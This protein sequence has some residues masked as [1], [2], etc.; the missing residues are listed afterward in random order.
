MLNRLFDYE[1]LSTGQWSLTVGSIAAVATIML[2]VFLAWKTTKAVWRI[3]FYEKYKVEKP[4][5][6]K[7]ESYLRHL[8]IA[9][10]V[11]AVVRALNLDPAFYETESIV[12]RFSLFLIAYII[13][14][15]AKII[16]WVLANILAHTYELGHGS[17]M[18]YA[19]GLSNGKEEALRTATSTVRYILVVMGAL[20]LLRNINLD[21]SLY[22][23]ESS[24]QTVDFRISK[25]LVVALILLAARFISWLISNIA[26]YGVY[27]RRDI[28]EGSQFAINQLMKYVIYLVAI[29][30]SLN[31]LGLNMTLL[32]GGAA[33]L[34][35]GVGLGL[36]QTFNDFFSGLVLLF[37]R[38]VS[39]GDI[40]SVNGV[41]GTVKKIGLR[42]SIIET[43]SNRN[44]IIP[45]SKLVN[46]AVLNWNHFD[47]IVRFEVHVGVAYGSDTQLVLLQ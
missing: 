11:V 7:F 1:V 21:F 8:I 15:I 27:R 46:D 5:A 26:L 18:N 31:S 40:L 9:I 43:L 30:F 24:G 44:I 14:V 25:F 16:D 19:G 47:D 34:L 6:R 35:V 3:R 20:L 29:F 2:L 36:Q 13:L 38:S 41:Q 4:K 45:N 32:L 33:A 37:E 42:A 17:S 22:T 23:Y 28:D 39:V 12:L 10:A